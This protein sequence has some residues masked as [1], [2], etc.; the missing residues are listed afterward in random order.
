MAELGDYLQQGPMSRK[1]VTVDMMDYKY[2]ETCEDPGELRAILAKLKSHEEGN[3]PHLENTIEEKLM[4]LLPEKERR[5]VC[6]SV[7]YF[8]SKIQHVY[9]CALLTFMFR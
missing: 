9:K 6:V 3:F 1:E 2:V 8:L 4:G 5:K 7:S